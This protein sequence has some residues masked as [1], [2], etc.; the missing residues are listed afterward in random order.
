MDHLHEM[1]GA[2]RPAVDPASVRRRRQCVDQGQDGVHVLAGAAEHQ[3]VTLL[4][5]PD[6]SRHAGVDESDLPFGQQQASSLGI[7]IVRVRAVDHDVAGIESMRQLAHVFFR[8]GACRYHQPY[9]ARTLECGD[10]VFEAVRDLH[11][12]ILRKLFACPG[13][14]AEAAHGNA[15]PAE[16]PRHAS[17]HAAESDQACAH[18]SLFAS[19]ASAS[20][21]RRTISRMPP[22][23]KYSTSAGASILTVVSNCTREPSCRV[24]LTRAFCRGVMP[25]PMPRTSYVSKPVRPRDCGDAPAS[26]C[27][28][29]MPMQTRLLR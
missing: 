21:W 5:S 27:S 9:D 3:A 10:H 23:R 28:G 22:W 24:T 6:A 8:R 7:A 29:R 20:N 19:F 17:A 11:I 2:G 15:V 1:A 18:G 13:P 12:A 14:T 26:N 4:E 16:A 25:A